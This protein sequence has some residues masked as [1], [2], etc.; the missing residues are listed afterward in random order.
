LTNRFTSGLK[1]ILVISWFNGIVNLKR[2][3]L[4]VLNFV[5]TPFAILF[6]IFIFGGPRATTYGLVGGV[7]SSIVSSS[8]IIE[9]DAAFIRLMLK[10]QDM[11]VA[12][13]CTPLT[14]VAGLALSELVNGAPGIVIFLILLAH[15]NPVSPLGG[16]IIGVSV[17]L[18]WASIA[19]LG[20]FI[21]TFARDPRDLWV[22]SPILTVLLSFLPP[23][24]YPISI[25]PTWIRP[26]AYLA[27]TTYP[28]QLIRMSAGITKGDPLVYLAGIIAYTFI[29]IVVAGKRMRWREA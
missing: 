5:L 8:I 7:I 9:T 19:S 3:P 12:S 10:V 4:S 17:V 1:T 18:T 28:A 13:P 14:Y 6:F 2:S 11:F 22:Y 16:V 25:I 27:P 24:Y 20:F 26:I 15:F 29:L 21:S 23:V